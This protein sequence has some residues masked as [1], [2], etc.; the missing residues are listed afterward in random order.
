[1]TSSITVRI[2]NRDEATLTWTTGRKGPDGEII[3]LTGVGCL[4]FL[5]ALEDL[6]QRLGKDIQKIPIP[7]GKDH[8]SLILKELIL[9]AQGKWAPPFDEEELCHCRKVPTETVCSAIR[10]G[11][12]SAVEVS[13]RTSASTSC[14]TC[15]PHVEALI[16]YIA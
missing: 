15:R 9:R 16:K 4:E 14:G 11:A 2:L 6:R 3:Q 13:D 8:A 10:A 1:M 12:H 7:Q 5:K